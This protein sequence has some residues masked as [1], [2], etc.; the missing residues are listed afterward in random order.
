VLVDLSGRNLK[1]Q[2]K[3]ASDWGSIL[4]IIVGLA[5]LEP[6]MVAVKSMGTGEQIAVHSG[7]LVSRIETELERARG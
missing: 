5:E 1:K 7:D 3:A 4:S 6:G 2:L